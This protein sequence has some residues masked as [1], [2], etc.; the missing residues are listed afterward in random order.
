LAAAVAA[1]G[2]DPADQELHDLRVLGKKLRYAAEIA[3]P[4]GGKPV[5]TLVKATKRLQDVL[6]EHQDSCVAETRLRG[7]N[8]DDVEQAFVAGRLVERERVRQ[9]AVRAT[10]RDAFVEVDEAATALS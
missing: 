5:R 3:A 8:P 6:G 10:W 2:V 7:L 9:V 1:M 4:V